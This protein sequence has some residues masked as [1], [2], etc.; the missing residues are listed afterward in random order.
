MWINK[1]RKLQKIEKALSELRDSPY[2]PD[3]MEKDKLYVLKKLDFE[4]EEFESI[5]RCEN[6]SFLDYPCYY[7]LMNKFVNILRPI[8]E[9]LLST[10]PILFYE[11]EMRRQTA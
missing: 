8:I 5:F 7:P 10:R 9:N 6:H 1:V 4:P 2:N 11:M 3:L